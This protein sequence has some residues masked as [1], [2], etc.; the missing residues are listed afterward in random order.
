V[1]VELLK[2]PSTALHDPHRP[3]DPLVVLEL[4]RRAVM[5]DGIETQ[6]CVHCGEARASVVAAL[7]VPGRYSSI[8][9]RVSLCERCH[10]DILTAYGKVRRMNRVSRGVYYAQLGAL[11]LFMA[12]GGGALMVSTLSLLLLG[13]WGG[14]ALRRRRL[15]RDQP[16]LLALGPTTL[17]LRT[18]NTWAR[19]LSDE[20]P[21][22]LARPALKPVGPASKQ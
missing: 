5:L 17:R 11:L 15:L 14:G 19:V 10:E 8:Q 12:G 20:K 18:P 1:S 16:R 21:A 4:E 9:V 7:P 3:K 2:T 13:T 22:A 6:T